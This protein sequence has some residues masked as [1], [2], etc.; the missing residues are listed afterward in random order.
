[1]KKAL[2]QELP[3]ANPVRIGSRVEAVVRFGTLAKIVTRHD[4]SNM[5]PRGEGA[6]DAFDS[7]MDRDDFDDWD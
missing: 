7:M 3:F 2:Q 1:M 4:I 5:L 6:Q